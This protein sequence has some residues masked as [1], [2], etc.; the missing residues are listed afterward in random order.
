MWNEFIL[1]FNIIH[2]ELYHFIKSSFGFVAFSINIHLFSFNVSN[3]KFWIN[4]TNNAN[5]AQNIN[6]S[7][8]Y[9]INLINSRYQNDC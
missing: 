4:N 5:N 2:T 1:I 7:F 9:I 3:L 6:D 8:K